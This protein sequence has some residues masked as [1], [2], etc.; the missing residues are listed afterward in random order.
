MKVLIADDDRAF[1]HILVA[2]L[3]KEGFQTFVAID[4]IQTMNAA[5]DVSPQIILLD[6]KMPGGSGIDLLK[7][8]KNSGKTAHI[9]VIVISACTDPALLQQATQFG[10]EAL[11]PKPLDLD[12]LCEALRRIVGLPHPGP[13]KVV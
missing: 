8:F 13:A 4:A 11:F 6:L 2:R 10:A 1:A 3:L 7:R 12:A 5:R 9:P